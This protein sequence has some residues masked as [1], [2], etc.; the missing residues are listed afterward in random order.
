MCRR[1]FICSYSAYILR[2]AALSAGMRC[3]P[4]GQ[5]AR[6]TH[7]SSSGLCTTMAGCSGCTRNGERSCATVIRRTSCGSSVS[8]C[9]SARQRV[10]SARRDRHLC[11]KQIGHAGDRCGMTGPP[12][13]HYSGVSPKIAEAMT[14]LGSG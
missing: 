8:R 10:C 5:I 9:K 1:S 7:R 12:T 13:P 14:E 6:G 11:A 4:F 3:S 2:T